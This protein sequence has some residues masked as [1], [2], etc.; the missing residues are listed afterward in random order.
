MPPLSPPQ[1]CPG[2]PNLAV[3]HAGTQVWRVHAE[4]RIPDASNTTVPGPGRGGR[5][6]SDDG[7]CAY[8]YLGADENAAIAETL[9][10]DLPFDGRPR[11]V[12]RIKLANA[13]LSSLTVSED[14]NVVSLC[15]AD[16]TQVGQDVWL[17]SCDPDQYPLTRRWAAAIRSWVLSADGLVYRC[18]HDQNRLAWAR[19]VDNPAP[20]THPHLHTTATPIRLDGPVGEALVR[21]VLVDHNATLSRL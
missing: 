3:L 15:G 2:I 13:M 18:R 9:C 14:L 21:R 17:T 19:F 10:R 16:A 12:P 7:F 8:T 6:D 20:E 5:F 1:E 11:M 4:D